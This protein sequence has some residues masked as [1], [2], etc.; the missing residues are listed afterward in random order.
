MIHHHLQSLFG[1]PSSYFV[2]K[3]IK[4]PIMLPLVNSLLSLHL[5]A[6]VPQCLS[7][8]RRRTV[9]ILMCISFKSFMK[10]F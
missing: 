4:I 6:K 3:S 7:D 9:M 5:K 1:I 10:T 8:S 2:V